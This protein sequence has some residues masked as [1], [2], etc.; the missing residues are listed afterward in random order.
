[1]VITIYNKF[2][3][4]IDKIIDTV[5]THLF[6]KKTDLQKLDILLKNH[7][8]LKN[9]AIAA[10]NEGALDLSDVRSL[11]E[12]DSTFDEI[13]KLA[14]KKEI[15]PK[16]L[17]GKW[18]KAKE[19]FE[20]SEKTW[21]TV[22]TVAGAAASIITA[23]TALKTFQSKCAKSQNELQKVKQEDRERRAAIL[24]ELK[25]EGVINDN[26]G[27]LQT[28][29]Q[30]WRELH[31]KHSAVHS[32]NLRVIDKIA[33]GITSFIDKFDKDG[34]GAKRLHDDL[35]KAKE[36]ADKAAEKAHNDGL[37]KVADETKARKEAEREDYKNHR[38][39]ELAR[40]KMES[41]MQAEGRKLA[42]SDNSSNEETD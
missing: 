36:K 37:K 25:D 13:L 16:T 3:E 6:K 35:N 40:K 21:K 19:K 14:R 11:K 1:M 39:E 8:D 26:T 24:A 10:F 12:L 33:N 15:D 32:Q 9:E 4:F 41:F 30:I 28:M 2:V 38:R 27:K 5:R 31:G 29:L 18:E 34:T 20:K 23:A 7:P 42:N 22:A 17:R